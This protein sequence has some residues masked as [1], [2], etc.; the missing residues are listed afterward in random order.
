[1]AN[2]N[3]P[4]PQGSKA[5]SIKGFGENIGELSLC[6][7]VSH[8]D[9]SLFNMVSQEVVSPL[10]VSHSFVEDWDFGYR[11]DTGVVA[12]EGNTLKDHSKLSHGVHNP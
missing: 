3:P 1:M 7:N 12:H 11:D 2:T 10:K 8:L 4:P 5:R 9:V 6:I